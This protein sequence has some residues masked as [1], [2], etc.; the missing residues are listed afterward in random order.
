M[1]VRNH[2]VKSIPA[3]RTAAPPSYFMNCTIFAP[4]TGRVRRVIASRARACPRIALG[5]PAVSLRTARR[6]A[7]SWDGAVEAAR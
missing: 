5:Q 1:V 3:H 6:A 7:E 2:N 4:G